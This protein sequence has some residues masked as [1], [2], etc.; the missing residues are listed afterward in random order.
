MSTD[1]L[2]QGLPR[3]LP[4]RDLDSEA[5]WTG[6]KDGKL[7]IHRC[8]DCGYRVH[9]PTS[10]CPKCEGR[11][12][13]PEPVSGRATILSM[14]VNHKQWLPGLKVPYILAMVA[15]EEQDDVHLISNIMDAPVES[16]AIGDKVEV[17]FEPAADI[18][19]PLFR[20]V[21]A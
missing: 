11:Q 10:F 21:R 5:F 20:P 2:T 9:P 4:M 14:S 3:P 1:P 7:M 15:I 8:Q 17:F 12:V 6:G 13:A 19:V 16:V 18:W